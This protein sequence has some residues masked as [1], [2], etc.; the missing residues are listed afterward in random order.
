MITTSQLTLKKR[1]SDWW[2]N[3]IMVY[4]MTSK[5]GCLDFSDQWCWIFGKLSI[6]TQKFH[7]IKTKNKEEFQAMP[8][9][10]DILRS[11]IFFVVI[12]ITKSELGVLY[13]AFQKQHLSYSYIIFLEKTHNP[14]AQEKEMIQVEN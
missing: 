7:K 11:T 4:M 1:R 9:L 8:I 5:P 2:Q 6:H 3:H 13:A 10:L 12:R 14:R